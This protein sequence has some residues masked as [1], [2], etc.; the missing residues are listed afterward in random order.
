MQPEMND[1]NLWRLELGL[2]PVPLFEDGQKNQFVLL[3][4]NRGNFCLDFNKERLDAD[5]RNNAWSSNVG[6]YVGLTDRYIEVQRWDRKGRS[7]E[8]FSRASVF[9]NLER[10]HTYLEKDEPRREFSIISHVIRVFRSLRT[11]L[12]QEADGPTSLKAFLYLLACVTDDV[13]RSHLSL[14]R[15]QLDAKATEVANAIRRDDWDALTDELIKGRPIEGLVP[16]PTLLLRHSS[17]QIFQEAHY[18][19]VNIPQEQLMLRGFPPAPAAL[20][21][22]R[23]GAGLHFTPPALARSLV[24][25]SIRIIGDLPTHLTIFDPACGSGEFLREILRQLK[26][27]EYKGHITLIGWDIS[28]AACDMARFILSWEMRGYE[29]RISADIRCLD[30]I[31]IEDWPREV[32]IIAMN[33]PFVSWQ[34]MLLQQRE[35]VTRV[36]GELAR[37]RPDL[38]SA[39]IL[40]ATESL[41]RGGVLASI[42]PA[43]FL[44]GDSAA[45]IRGQ[46][47]E[48]L[49]TKLVARLGSHQ[50]F[51]S[52]LIDAAFYLGRANGNQP[53][54][55]VAFWADYRPHSA[56][57]GLRALRRVRSINRHNAY[58]V[59]K[60]GFSIYLTSAMGRGT[61]S[62]APR[63]YEA[64][65]LTYTL[66]HLSKVKNL[67]EV[68]QGV[69]TGLN[70]TFILSK[71]QWR[72]L[73][74]KREKS[75][76]RPAVLNESIK[77]GVL[78][79]VAYLFYPYGKFSIES[80]EALRTELKTYYEE[81]LLPNKEVLS[82]RS[83]RRYA[84]WWEL[85]EHRVWQERP[86]S[87]LVSTYFGDAGSFAWDSSGLFVVV[88]GFGW[89][90]KPTN[91]FEELPED[92]G[93]AY[94]VVLNSRL[95]SKLL[96]AS[97]NHVG[98]GQWNL[99]KKFVDQVPLP[100]LLGEQ[101][102][103]NILERLSELGRNIHEGESVDTQERE[104]LVNAVYGIDLNT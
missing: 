14:R 82:K 10:F 72:S 102:N 66:Q 58:P 6:H 51:H 5:T 36:L 80:E 41:R 9:E 25:E 74:T 68:K 7:F 61:G 32:D 18:E 54:P 81:V 31:V 64:W 87:K 8:R 23:K 65:R 42:V 2:Y 89:I 33:P 73:P 103:P 79:D 69:R 70:K 88:Q 71:E 60:D 48:V 45:K 34:D 62:W 90:H 11:S 83:S 76:F 97:S 85:S 16:N 1:I 47:S 91:K 24:E 4:G 40:R 52:A 77:D 104:E 37:I 94:L 95:F 28:Q 43:S 30:S 100:D 20:A 12:G 13:R 44:D 53:E 17:G 46:L 29:N 75:Y 38:S 27:K 86:Q 93:L 63:P 15:W 26:I 98:G 56:S 3:N 99:S 39:F 55:T 49:T 21:Q 84:K 96:S 78:T 101:I 22:A 67:F 35:A 57:A 19:A 50:L 92:V 59:D